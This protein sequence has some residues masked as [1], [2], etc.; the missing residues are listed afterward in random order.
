[1][2]ITPGEPDRSS[3]EPDDSAES[4]ESEERL[5]RLQAVT[6]IALSRLDLAELLPELLDRVRDI[7][8]T[9]TAAVLLMDQSEQFLVATAARGIE[10]EVHQGSRIPLGRGF[11]GR[12]AAERRPVV[13]EHVTPASVVNPVLLLKGMRSMLGVPLLSGDAVLGVL[14]VGTLH[15]RH[16]GPEDVALLE[17]VAHRVTLAIQA[18]QSRADASAAIALQRS[19]APPQLPSVAGLDMAARYVPGGVYGVGGDWYDV[20]SLPDGLVGIVVGDVMGHGL[21]AATVMGRLRSALRAYALE[22]EDPATVLDRLD[23][24]IQH[25]EPGQTATVIYAVYDPAASRFMVSSAGHLPPVVAEPYGQASLMPVPSDLIL[26]VEPGMPRRSTELSMPPGGLL[27]MFTDGLIERRGVHLD[28]ALERVRRT[29]SAD[30]PSADVAC[31]D[32][33]A[34]LIGDGTVDDDVALL[35]V[36]CDVDVV[37]A[38]AG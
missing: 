17:Q 20:F 28:T 30:V 19:L 34:A 36:R 35:V 7:L 1:M 31:A 15:P 8:H 32:L 12:I 23:R 38:A 9:D 5:R 22:T 2:Q 25:F 24:Q 16:F 37:Q 14:H 26:G 18:G 6:D 33:M 29:V 10:E 11:A 21:R 27:A 3:G 4:R 13:L